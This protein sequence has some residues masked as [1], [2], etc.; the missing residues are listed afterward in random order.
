MVRRGDGFPDRVYLKGVPFDIEI[1][2]VESNRYRPPLPE[3]E[4]SGE[5]TARLPGQ[6]VSLLVREGDSVV[7]DQ[8]LLVLEAMKMENEILAPKDGIVSEIFA[9]EGQLV[10]K[11]E[12]LLRID[13]K[14]GK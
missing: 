10:A 14:T 1:E 9:P 4:V 12:R 2:R 8:P 11:D 5:V 7:K 3:K 13:G 6:V